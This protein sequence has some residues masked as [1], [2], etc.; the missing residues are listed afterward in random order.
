MKVL[1]FMVCFAVLN[2][3][4]IG[5]LF[6]AELLRVRDILNVTGTFFYDPITITPGQSGKS[7]D[8]NVYGIPGPFVHKWFSIHFVGLEETGVPNKLGEFGF[9]MERLPSGEWRGTTEYGDAVPYPMATPLI[10][11]IQMG[12]V[13]VIKPGSVI[14]I[15]CDDNREVNITLPGFKGYSGTLY[16]ST[17]GELFTDRGLTQPVEKMIIEK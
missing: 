1:K 14:K 13:N 16:I 12:T 6:S 3:F 7:G 11:T 2:V 10:L 9:M 5:H 15:F 8:K 17:N 4:C